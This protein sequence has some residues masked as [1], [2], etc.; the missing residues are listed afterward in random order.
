METL[1][2]LVEELSASLDQRRKQ[3]QREI[4]DLDLRLLRVFRAVVQCGGFAAAEVDLNKS[5]SAISMDMTALE[6]RL[7]VT[8][9]RRGRAGFALTREGEM[10]YGAT[11]RLFADLER[12]NYQ[13]NVAT[14]ILSGAITIE[15]DDSFPFTA[16][17]LLSDMLARVTRKHPQVHIDLQSTSAIDV[18][19]NLLEGKIDLGITSISKSP[20]SFTMIALFD[21]EMGLYCG[22]GH[23]LFAVSEHELTTRSLASH[24]VIAVTTM[25]SSELKAIMGMLDVRASASTDVSRVLLVLSGSYLGLIPSALADHWVQQGK[26][27]RLMPGRLRYANRCC[28]AWKKDAP[29]NLIRDT[30]VREL[31]TSATAIEAQA[32]ESRP[33]RVRPD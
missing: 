21:E 24:P 17:A 16:E 6:H 20:A 10:V 9:C 3:V 19:R 32:T 4:S 1:R 27:R 12:F 25:L 11:L 14:A 5:K 28:A 7:G 30:F 8:L 2:P 31:K 18:E 13:V 22:R 15:M 33:G 29:T 26:M 23:P